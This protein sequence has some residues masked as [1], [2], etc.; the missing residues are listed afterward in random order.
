MKVCIW[1]G[2][3]VGCIAFWNPLGTKGASQVALVVKNLPANAGDVGDKGLIPGSVRSLGGGN[4][5][6]LQYSCLRNPVDRGLACYSPWDHRVRHDWAQTE[7]LSP[8][9]TYSPPS[10]PWHLPKY[11][12]TPWIWPCYKLTLKNAS[13]CMFLVRSLCHVWLSATPWT[14]A[15]QASLSFTISLSLLRIISIE[16]VMPSNHLVLCRPL[17]LPSIFP[18]IRVFSNKSTLHIRWPKY[19]SFNFNI[20]PSSECSGLI[21][22][23]IDWFDLLT[24]QYTLLLLLLLLSRFS[25]LRLYTTP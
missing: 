22:S 23:R 13:Q 24:A 6:P 4:G 8:F 20:S 1:I 19:W 18:S 25:R 7:I 17:L 5:N 21:S 14:A 10:C 11:F 2:K 3:L 15:H 16:S 12:L 9:N